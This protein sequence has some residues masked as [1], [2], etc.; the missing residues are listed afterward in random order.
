VQEPWRAVVGFGVAAAINVS[1]L[2]WMGH[3]A[4]KLRAEQDRFEQHV[5][6]IGAS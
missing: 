3:K 5:A 4:R 1:V 2:L 6:G